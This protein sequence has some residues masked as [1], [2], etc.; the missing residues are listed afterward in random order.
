M[1]FATT[2]DVA[3][4]LG[5][6]LT[7]AEQAQV[8]AVLDIV[9]GLLRDAVSKDSAWTPSPVPAVLEEL[10][11]QKA[12]SVVSNPTNLASESKN[13]GSYSHSQTFQRSQDGGIFLTD[14]EARLARFAVWGTNRATVMLGSTF[15]EVDE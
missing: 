12:V 7:V 2:S 11:I 13:L 9:D 5:R 8:S 6:T 1:A 4:R 14:A 10:S 3:T 15:E